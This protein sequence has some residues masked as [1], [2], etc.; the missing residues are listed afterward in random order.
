M[1]APNLVNAASGVS[2]RTPRRNLHEID[3]NLLAGLLLIVGLTPSRATGPAPGRTP[4]WA[5]VA[6]RLPA[7]PRPKNKRW[8]GNPIDAFV[9]ATLEQAGLS[10]SPEADR[11]TLIRRL[12]L[13]LTGFP[14]TPEQMR[15]FLADTQPQAW[16]RLVD[17][18]L[19][20]P[21]FGE[22]WARHWL[23]LARYADSS[24]YQIDR[25]RP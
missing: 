2:R 24:G 19:A 9:L 5:F 12:S 4:H 20:S 17:S 21:H 23:D 16:E 22:R 15:A 25:P 6:P 11:A 8:I 3:R 1:N 7:V 14:P 10:P 13:D 18:F